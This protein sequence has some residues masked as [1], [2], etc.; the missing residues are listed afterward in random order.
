MLE[1]L[2]ALVANIFDT[3]IKF[4]KTINAMCLTQLNDKG[5][6]NLP[7]SDFPLDAD[8]N[9]KE[10]AIEHV[11]GAYIRHLRGAVPS[12]STIHPIFF[13]LRWKDVSKE[14]YELMLPSLSLASRFLDEPQL[15]TY[16]KG[17]LKW[18]LEVVNDDEATQDAGQILHTFQPAPLDPWDSEWTWYKL[19][20]LKDR[21]TFQFSSRLPNGCVA[22]TGPGDQTAK[23]ANIF[24]DIQFLRVFQRKLEASQNSMPWSPGSHD[25]SALLRTQFSF[26]IT[27]VHEVMHAIWMTSN[28]VREEPSP[29]PPHA[30]H[31]VRPKE[32]FFRDGRMN[33]LGACWEDHVFGGMI[34]MMD[35]PTGAIMPYGMI[36][37]PFPGFIRNYPAAI[38]RGNPRKWGLEWQTEYP[39]ETKYI[40]KMFSNQMWDD[41]QRFGVKALRRKRKLGYRR[42]ITDKE[43]PPLAPGEA[44]RGVAPS[45]TSSVASRDGEEDDEK[46]VIRR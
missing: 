34:H 45:P 25:E 39:I 17:F 8:F 24:V 29:F 14:D 15:L 26:A 11:T 33:E 21:L 13:L 12:V 20:N 19:W 42:Y 4:D 7:D 46:G 18:K 37:V 6:I 38:D 28:P 30:P 9:S 41:V 40:R 3:R 5:Y 23:T 35:T 16:I 31:L 36:S 32:P 2:K 1:G 10:K 27:L 44:V 43:Y 22:G